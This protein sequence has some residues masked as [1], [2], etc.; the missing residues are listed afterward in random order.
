M[1][2]AMANP[3][4]AERQALAA[5]G[6][7]E[8][9]ADAA[10]YDATHEAQRRAADQAVGPGGASS[11]P[12]VPTQ[13][14]ATQAAAATSAGVTGKST[15]VG[16]MLT[17]LK[18]YVTKTDN[19]YALVQ[20]ALLVAVISG[21]L[22]INSTPDA[23]TLATGMAG[24]HM[25]SDRF[26]SI[27]T[28]DEWYGWVKAV[29]T[30]QQSRLAGAGTTAAAQ[31]ITATLDTLLYGLAIDL[32][33]VGPK[34]CPTRDDGT[35]QILRIS[36]PLRYGR[37][38]ALDPV[39][40]P[41]FSADY[42]VR[43]PPPPNLNASQANAGEI[44]NVF[45][46]E[47]AF[48]VN[49]TATP[50]TEPPSASPNATKLRKG[51][52]PSLCKH[53]SV[54]GL[55]ARYSCNDAS[56]RVFIDASSLTTATGFSDTL[57]A[58]DELREYG[59]VTQPDVRGV[60]VTFVLMQRSMRL[61]ARL[62]AML[63]IGGGGAAASV[64][65][66]LSTW[67]FAMQSADGATSAK[68]VASLIFDV[69]IIFFGLVC[70]HQTLFRLGLSIEINSRW[71]NAVDVWLALDFIVLAVL[72]AYCALRFNLWA[73]AAEQFPPPDGDDDLAD[74]LGRVL[75]YAGKE[76]AAR[77]VG[78]WLLLCTVFRFLYSLR[79][80]SR[81]SLVFETLAAAA[82]DFVSTV[83]LSL[84]VVLA[85]ALAGMLLWSTNSAG[86]RSL[87]RAVLFLFNFMISVD[88]GDNYADLERVHPTVT[89]IFFV[90]LFLIS[91]CVLMNVLVAVLATAFAAAA[92]T[93]T[94]I[95]RPVWTVDNVTRDLHSIMARVFEKA[96]GNQ[97]PF[98]DEY[99]EPIPPPE[100]QLQGHS[101]STADSILAAAMRSTSL[102]PSSLPAAKP[103]GS[104]PHRPSD[105]AAIMKYAGRGHFALQ[106]FANRELNT[107]LQIVLLGRNLRPNTLR[108]LHLI[109]LLRR[110]KK[111]Q[112]NSALL[113]NEATCCLSLFDPAATTRMVTKAELH[114]G[115]SDA[116]RR[117]WLIMQKL[118]G[119]EKDVSAQLSVQYRQLQELAEALCG[120]ELG[121]D[122]G[123]ALSGSDSDGSQ[124]G[125][126]GGGPWGRRGR[127]CRERRGGGPAQRPGAPER[128]KPRGT[129]PRRRRT[130]T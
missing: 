117:R 60:S 93:Q 104:G 63:E 89:T 73:F 12:P 102:M 34:P 8:E 95:R 52:P 1:Q 129:Q 29:V 17:Y 98:L 26:Y 20:F 13:A 119:V 125:D 65:H 71:T 82:T 78:A 72:T 81:V 113:S 51:I 38:R 87:G 14:P 123:D 74:A 111:E 36:D 85:Y 105:P 41:L 54:R 86:F 110:I 96:G 101:L 6:T 122:M 103:P 35:S 92:M 48:T 83:M 68:G 91:W 7:A 37:G 62:S 115:V 18:Y 77:D 22:F 84:T 61:N 4:V 23:T 69:L 120:A 121:A 16:P 27:T 28:A 79:Y 88:V 130:S 50:P 9:A 100:Q 39:C 112:G 46:A 11:P 94:I 97:H 25:V 67:T 10:A 49:S 19:M 64:T 47:N 15:T 128:R 124:A 3:V 44:A 43:D 31:R 114:V 80:V 32:Y 99:G 126:R 127:G 106:Q 109:D 45:Y 107:L 76:E 56:S 53:Y 118:I 33:R 59:W 5:R 2:G 58:I 42:A 55:N 75:A 24:Q 108:A 30:R 21:S 40:L 90:T 66:T 116:S 70:L 57:A